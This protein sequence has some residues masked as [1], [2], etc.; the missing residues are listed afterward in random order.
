LFEFNGANLNRP[1]ALQD[2]LDLVQ[3]LALFRG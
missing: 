3:S 1:R 2:L